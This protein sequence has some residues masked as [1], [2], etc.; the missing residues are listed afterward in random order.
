LIGAFTSA[1]LVQAPGNDRQNSALYIAPFWLVAG[2]LLLATLIPAGAIPR[3]T[4]LVLAVPFQSD[5]FNLEPPSLILLALLA[6]TCGIQNNIFLV[7]RN[8]VFRTTHVTGTTSDLATHLARICF[9]YHRSPD[10]KLLEV[11]LAAIRAVSILAFF[12]GAA[13]GFVAHRTLGRLAL[14]LPLA[15]A[16]AVAL[17][18][19][20]HFYLKP[21]QIGRTLSRWPDI[22][23]IVG[24]G[25]SG[26]TIAPRDDDKDSSRNEEK[27]LG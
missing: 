26:K 2:L 22:L 20:F 11:R 13:A 10:A 15:N 16:I 6:L 23:R 1:A 8:L 17:F 7:E 24:K 5:L 3:E 18:V 4:L 19:T 21:S 14:G 12:S 27:P 9:G 25:C